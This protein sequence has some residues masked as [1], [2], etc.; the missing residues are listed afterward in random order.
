MKQDLDISNIESKPTVVLVSNQSEFDQLMKHLEK[1]GC[2]WRGGQKAT[3]WMP[4]H[5]E[6]PFGIMIDRKILSWHLWA[7]IRSLN[8]EAIPFPEYAAKYIKPKRDRIRIERKKYDQMLF[9]LKIVQTALDNRNKEIDGWVKQN[10]ELRAERDAAIAERDAARSKCILLNDENGELRSTLSQ[11]RNER[12][13]VEREIKEVADIGLKWNTK[14]EQLTAERDRLREAMEL[15]KQSSMRKSLEIDRLQAENAELKHKAAEL[16]KAYF[17]AKEARDYA[18]ENWNLCA[19]SLK[20][21][22]RELEEQKIAAF[23]LKATEHANLDTLA[24]KLRDQRDTARF[25][26]AL[27]FLAC[28]GFAVAVLIGRLV[29][30]VNLD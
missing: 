3:E 9:D 15:H 20:V 21:L 5:V 29:P 17:A 14:A 26:A 25:L 10:N 16:N 7:M 27:F 30:V 8:P 11:V 6:P 12:D 23:E 18:S 2:V 19:K 1:E 22:K 4:N 13:R 28:A 24:R